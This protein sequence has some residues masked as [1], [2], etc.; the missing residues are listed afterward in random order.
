MRS[1]SPGNCVKALYIVVRIACGD[2]ILCL[3]IAE[4]Q[5]AYDKRMRGAA[6]PRSADEWSDGI[7]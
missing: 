4:R 5:R 3:W 7:V 1:G 2:D 6:H